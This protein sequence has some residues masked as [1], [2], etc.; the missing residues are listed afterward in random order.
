MGCPYALE[1]FE[2]VRDEPV[3]LRRSSDPTRS[4]EVAGAGRANDHANDHA[5]LKYGR[6]GDLQEQ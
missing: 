3:R 5:S 2:L 6:L 1:I 4:D